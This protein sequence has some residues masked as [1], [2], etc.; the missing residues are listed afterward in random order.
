MEKPVGRRRPKLPPLGLD[1]R[2]DGHPPGGSSAFAEALSG[3]RLE[4]LDS[5]KNFLGCK[6][7]LPLSW[8]CIL[9]RER[10]IWAYYN[11]RSVL[12]Q[13]QKK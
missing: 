9:A 13:G 11:A 5:F 3:V 10:N 2:A 6:S 8:F 12:Y 4:K 7:L 1:R